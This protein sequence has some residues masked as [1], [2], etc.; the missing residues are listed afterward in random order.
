MPYLQV[1]VLLYSAAEQQ[2]ESLSKDI[3][4]SSDTE[5]ACMGVSGCFSNV[6][7]ENLFLVCLQQ[8]SPV[9]SPPHA[10]CFTPFFLDFYI[11]NMFS[12]KAKSSIWSILFFKPQG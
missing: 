5:R 11:S 2:Y 4:K 10:F 7:C 12:C 1:G 9:F 8:T 3:M 6:A